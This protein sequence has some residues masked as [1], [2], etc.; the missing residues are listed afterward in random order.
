MPAILK[1]YLDLDILHTIG[2]NISIQFTRQTNDKPPVV[3]NITSYTYTFTIYD[4]QTVVDTIPTSVI[5]GV[6]GIL[7]ASELPANLTWMENK[8]YNYAIKETNASSVATTIFKGNFI[9]ENPSQNN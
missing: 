2:D 7:K 8:R 4:G 1:P 6:N 3:V 9:C 5:D